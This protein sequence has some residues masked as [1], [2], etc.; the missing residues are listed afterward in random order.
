MQTSEIIYAA[1][2]FF[3]LTPGILLSL[4]PKSSPKVVAATHAVVFAI[5]FCLTR[6]I[7]SG[8]VQP[9]GIDG[10]CNPNEIDMS[11]NCV[12]CPRGKKPSRDGKSCVPILPPA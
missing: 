4:P 12:A 8:L 11:G 10:F 7:V 6:S 2:L 9:L 3:L 5:V 1:V